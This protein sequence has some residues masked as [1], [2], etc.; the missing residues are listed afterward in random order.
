MNDNGNSSDT[1]SQLMEVD[2]V[3]NNPSNS[4]S[5]ERS[6]SWFDRLQ[7]GAK[8][9]PVDGS[10]GIG[11]RKKWYSKLASQSIGQNKNPTKDISMRSPHLQDDDNGT[12]G[13]EEDNTGGDEEDNT[14]GE[15][16]GDSQQVCF[17]EIS[18]SSHLF[19]RLISLAA[20]GFARR[21]FSLGL[22]FSNRTRGG[23]ANMWPWGIPWKIPRN[24]TCHGGWEH[25]SGAF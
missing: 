15:E 24:C 1:R 2:S 3:A 5:P 19:R 7:K 16:G 23:S 11:P 10:T 13:D 22:G 21:E 17:I 25:R 4:N 20:S 18:L 12:D 6:T 8:S 9:G 14:G